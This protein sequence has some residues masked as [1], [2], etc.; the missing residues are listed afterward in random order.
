MNQ[1]QVL[2]RLQGFDQEI[3]Q[4]KARLA[5]I[6]QLLREDT[7]VRNAEQTV[8]EIEQ[9]LAPLRAQATDLDLEIKAIT[10]KAAE[11]EKR[12]YSG[13]VTNHKEMQDMQEEIASLKR[14]RSKLENDLLEAMIAIETA[15]AELQEA[16]QALSDIRTAWT[17]ETVTLQEEQ[18]ELLARLEALRA[19]RAALIKTIE[20]A[21]FDT[22]KRLYRVK[23]GQVVSPIIESNCGVCGVSQ[24]S[25]KI[26]QVRQGREIVFCSNC[27]RILAIP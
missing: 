26:Q 5:T 2:Y 14:R 12:L 18:T 16:Q 15:E 23:Q 3:Q 22:Y 19:E 13:S 4:C 9:G 20:P 6:E 1:A 8:Q 25:Q 21:A 11:V 10:N 17:E 27:G 7:R 24:T